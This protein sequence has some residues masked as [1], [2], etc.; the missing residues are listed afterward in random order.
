MS[1][2]INLTFK[3]VK[4][5]GNI[6]KNH[7]FFSELLNAFTFLFWLHPDLWHLLFE[8]HPL[9]ASGAECKQD[10]MNYCK[11]YSGSTALTLSTLY[12]PVGKKLRKINYILIFV[13]LLTKQKL[14]FSGINVYT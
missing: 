13:T 4:S 2:S 14:K 12:F 10:F 7:S 8:C 9:T 5:L 3:N 1:Y 11:V 6:N